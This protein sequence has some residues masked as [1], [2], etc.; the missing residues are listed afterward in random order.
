MYASIPTTMGLSMTGRRGIVG[1]R[2]R[3]AHVDHYVDAYRRYVWPV[4]GVADLRLA[5]F[6]VLAAETG[7]FVDREHS[8]HLDRCDQL[9]AADPEWFQRTDRRVVDVTDADSQ[10]AGARWWEEMTAAGGVGMVVKPMSFV[11]R[12]A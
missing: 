7:V 1:Q 10:A 4:S 2:H 11:A 8:W 3:L 9:V 6:H 5:P 12:G